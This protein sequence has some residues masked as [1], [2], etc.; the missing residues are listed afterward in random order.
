MLKT[1]QIE[2]KFAFKIIFSA[3]NNLIANHLSIQ[4]I[5]PIKNFKYLKC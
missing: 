4:L 1:S 3:T 2:F 5:K